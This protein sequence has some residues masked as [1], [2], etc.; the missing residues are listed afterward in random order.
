VPQRDL[1]SSA[2]LTPSRLSK[3]ENGRAAILPNELIRLADA[4]SISVDALLRGPQTP[5][6]REG[7]LVLQA[8]RFEAQRTLLE[9]VVLGRFIAFALGELASIDEDGPAEPEPSP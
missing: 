3:L 6:G 8:R 9:G 1:A 7:F 5:P 2:G 4:L